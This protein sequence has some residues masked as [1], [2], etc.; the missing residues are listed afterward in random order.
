[1]KPAA[2]QPRI[3]RGNPVTINCP[4]TL[5]VCLAAAMVTSPAVAQ[6]DAAQELH[7]RRVSSPPKIDGVLD[8]DAWSSEPLP[9]GTWKSYNPMRGEAAAEA[10]QV[11]IA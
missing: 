5:V 1:M 11:W 9:L 3:Y 4:T 2:Y 10:T 8:D 7:A 6:G